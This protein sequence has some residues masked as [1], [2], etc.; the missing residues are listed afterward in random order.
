MKRYYCLVLIGLFFVAYSKAQKTNC[1]ISGTVDTSFNG[2]YM[3]LYG[4]DYS[5]LNPKINDSSLIQNGQFSFHVNLKT[6]GLLTSL[7]TEGAFTQIVIQPSNMTIN[8][9]GKEWYKPENIKLTNAAINEQY[10]TLKNKNNPFVNEKFKLYRLKDSLLEKH[11]DSSYVDLDNRIKVYENKEANS[12]KKFLMTHRNDYLSLYLLSYFMQLDDKPDTLRYLYGFLSDKLKKLPEG[13]KLSQKIKAI[14]AIENGKIA[15]DFQ[16]KDTAGNIITLKS[17]RGKYILLDFWAT[18]CG[19][20]IQSMPSMK[21]FY[22]R[23]QS[24][25]LQVISISFDTDKERWLKGIKQFDLNWTNVSELKGWNNELS[26]SYNIKYIPR[27][28]L[29]DPNGKKKKKEVDFS[30]NYF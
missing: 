25:G 5:N 1:N 6:P 7:Y 19:P 27:A 30:K 14:Y 2:K 28:I 29:I 4:I 17:F 11:P 26:T 10:Q 18:W 9:L 16:I 15:P 12:Q 24:K 23:N 8:L 13:E 20:C 3:H 22:T 21:A